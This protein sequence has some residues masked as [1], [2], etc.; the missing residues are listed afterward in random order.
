MG[1]GSPSSPDV[2][3]ELHA[4]LQSSA[5]RCYPSASRRFHETGVSEVAFCVGDSGQLA[6]GKLARSSGSERLDRAALECVIGEAGSFPA[7]H[8][9]CFA[10]PVKFGD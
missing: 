5:S 2:E 8:G 9:R 6:D 1:E 10:L 4:R 7:A 3:R